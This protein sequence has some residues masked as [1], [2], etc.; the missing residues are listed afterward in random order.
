LFQ[1]I[2]GFIQQLDDERLTF[3]EAIFEEDTLKVASYT[4]CELIRIHP[5][6][7]GN[8]RLARKCISYFAWRYGMLPPRFVG[9]KADYLDANRTWLQQR[10]IEHFMDY[11]RPD[12]V[13]NPT[14]RAVHGGRA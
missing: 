3:D 4:H 9:A 2:A 6:V 7:N 5:F 14:A 10:N 13:R 12:W 1:T 8:G 11:L